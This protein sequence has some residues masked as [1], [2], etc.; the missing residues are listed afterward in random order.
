MM[1]RG[2]FPNKPTL[3]G[4]SW[5]VWTYAGLPVAG[6]AQGTSIGLGYMAEFYIDFGV[7]L[8]FVPLFLFGILLGLIYRAFLIFSPSLDIYNAVVISV[9]LAHF[10]TYDAEIAKMLGAIAMK[11]VVYSVL[12]RFAGRWLHRAL[13]VG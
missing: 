1:P 4:D 13:I 7:P 11:S 8:M 2:L 3:G 9:F 6:D 10:S 5:L 12:L